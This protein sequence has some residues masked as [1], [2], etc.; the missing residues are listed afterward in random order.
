MEADLEAQLAV[1]QQAKAGVEA[2]L[3]ET[4]AALAREVLRPGGDF[5]VYGSGASPF[6]LPFFP[7]IAKNLNLRCFIVYHLEAADRQRAEATLDSLLRR[8]GLQHQIA[9]R[10]TLG[11]IVAG[12]QMVEQG[13]AIGNVVLKVD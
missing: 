5:V 13:R 12:H 7:L 9:A 11:D 1:L 3:G 6:S 8:D 10:L 2:S 4:Q